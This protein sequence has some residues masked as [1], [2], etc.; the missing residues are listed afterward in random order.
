MQ[1]TRPGSMEEIKQNELS[2]LFISTYES[3]NKP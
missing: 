1:S 3:V 2:F